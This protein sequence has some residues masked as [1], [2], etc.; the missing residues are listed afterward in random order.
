LRKEFSAFGRVWRLQIV[1]SV[2]TEMFKIYARIPRER[3]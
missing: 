3:R 2:A 1:G